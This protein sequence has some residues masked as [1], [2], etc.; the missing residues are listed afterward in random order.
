M[1]VRFLSGYYSDL[2]HKNKKRRPEDYWDAYFFCWGVKI[3]SFKRPFNIH[4]SSSK[5]AIT[6]GNFNLA[7]RHFGKWIEK[8]AGALNGAGDAILIPVPSKDGIKGTATFRSLEMTREALKGTKLAPHVL[9]GLRW[10]QKLTAA[11]E[12][13]SRSRAALAPLLEADAGVAGKKVILVDDLI[14]K[15]SSLLAAADVLKKS[16]A[17]VLGA[18][19]CGKTIYDLSTPHFG[20]QE[21][22][23][24]GELADWN[25]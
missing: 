3:G 16:G 25:G 19:V 6:A 12:G 13:G 4:T 24:T 5:T 21:F 23:L 1:K 20:E 8:S 11:H 14:T 15:G 2:A 9:A 7:R 18:I 10:K 22:E 17:T